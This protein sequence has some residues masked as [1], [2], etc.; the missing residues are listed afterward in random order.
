A[1]QAGGHGALTGP[2]TQ[3]KLPGAGLARLP[4][5]RG[6]SHDPVLDGRP[7][8]R[9]EQAGEQVVDELRQGVPRPRPGQRPPA[10]A[11]PPLP[12]AGPAGDLNAPPGI[13]RRKG[14]IGD[15][16]VRAGPAAGLVRAEKDLRPVVLHGDDTAFAIGATCYFMDHLYLRLVLGR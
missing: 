5:A 11:V 1:V 14:D 12:G 7:G 3:G 16:K 8:V 15:G 10:L 2:T 6:A 4:V 9:F 13:P